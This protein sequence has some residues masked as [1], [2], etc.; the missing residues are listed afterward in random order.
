MSDGSSASALRPDALACFRAAV[1][2]VEPERLVEEFL[3]DRADLRRPSGRVWLVG[4]GKAAAAM[5]RG[6]TS[7]LG[8]A[9]G[10]G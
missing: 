8:Q 5:T 1:E 10:G 6:A 9:I 2:A 7:V 4:V 3:E